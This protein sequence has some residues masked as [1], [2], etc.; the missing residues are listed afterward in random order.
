MRRLRG[1]FRR[2]RPAPRCSGQG[3]R[4]D[5]PGGA[6]LP[7]PP[8]PGRN[9]AAAGAADRGGTG[10]DAFTGDGAARGGRRWS[11][12]RGLSEGGAAGGAGRRGSAR[13]R[14]APSCR[15]CGARGAAAW[16]EHRPL[17]PGSTP[18]TENN[19]C[20]GSKPPAEPSLSPG[21]A[22]RHQQGQVSEDFTGNH[23]Q[24]SRRISRNRPAPP[25]P[26]SRSPRRGARSP[27]AGDTGSFT[28][29]A[30][31]PP[32]E[33][34]GCTEPTP[35]ARTALSAR[36]PEASP[37]R[38]R[39][40]GRPAPPPAPPLPSEING[41]TGLPPISCPWPASRCRPKAPPNRRRRG[42]RPCCPRQRPVPWRYPHEH[43]DADNATAHVP[44][45]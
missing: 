43:L 11:G 13:S 23:G 1:S 15:W 45:A 19:R 33:G 35:F 21:S 37:S 44:A 26:S 32:P 6:A 4:R 31:G 42:H 8:S 28:G 40:Q 9:R 20:T 7:T 5:G 39:A 16:A 41:C 30:P 12:W 34:R 24:N 17:S 10:D 2:R 27:D 36:R 22:T 38:R 25:T 18:A 14:S 29:A 3:A